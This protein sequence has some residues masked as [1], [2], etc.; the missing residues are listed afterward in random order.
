MLA[1]TIR[2]ARL[3][4]RALSESEIAACAESPL[5]PAPENVLAAIR[6]GSSAARSA[7]QATVLREYYL[8][9]IHGATQAALAS[10]RREADTLRKRIADLQN[11]AN[12]PQQMVSL[13]MAEPKPAHVLI[14]GD[15]Q[16]PGERVERE[17]P[18]FL[19]PFSAHEPRNRLGLARW[20]MRKDQPLVARVQVNRFWQ[21]LFGEGIVRTMGDFGMQGSYP[22][23]PELLDWLALEFVDSQ[24][25]VKHMLKL[26]LISHTYRQA[27]DDARRHAA[28]D[29]ENHLLWRASRVRLQAET[30]RDNALCAAGLLSA[31]I[32]G[33]P[34]FPYQPVDF[35]KGKNNGWPWN[36]SPGDDRYRRGIYTFW[37]RTT[38]FP[39]FAIFDAPDR[40]ECT[41][42]RPRTNT[43]LQAL[44]TLND[45]QFVEAARVLAQ[46]II[47]KA[48]AGAD[49]RIT[50]AFRLVL[51]RPPQP[52]ELQV[53]REFI[54]E[55]LII[56]QAN[57]AHL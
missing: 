43:P 12:H 13:E 56:Y 25:D 48:G 21:I 55:Q 11:E 51:A 54:A 15:F 2:G 3:H 20:L 10:P 32:G 31:K 40:A 33:P 50:H 36:V 53:T 34:V 24:W 9:H 57:L 39:S 27:S 14:R 8:L 49:Q 46:R 45:P 23:H 38:P 47:A 22:T 16:T 35:Y 18:A 6:T 30:V 7:E 41:F 19:P 1:G 5:P 4:D 52:R 29:P 37:R 26:M 28:Q 44:V 42:E 17:V